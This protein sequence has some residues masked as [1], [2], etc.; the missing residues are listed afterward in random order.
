[1]TI[2][3]T[4]L[5][6]YLVGCLI[7]DGGLHGSLT[8][9]TLDLDIVDRINKC[10]AV[11]GYFL[12]KRSTDIKRSCEYTITP[13]K[14]NN[15]MYEF[16]YKGVVYNGC[17]KLLHVLQ[18]DGYP[19]TSHDSL[20]SIT[21]LSTK[22]KKSTLLS[23]FPELSTMLSGR[24][25]KE[26]QHSTFIQLL[27]RL[28]LRCRFDVKRIPEEYLVDKSF[29]NR[30]LLFQGLMDTDGSISSSNRLE[31]CVSNEQLANDFKKLAESLGF[32]PKIYEKHPKYFNK[33]YNEFR[34]GHI[35]YRVVFHKLENIM[36]FLCLRKQTMYN[37]V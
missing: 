14:N 2:D 34:M 5:D 11:F 22:T 20:L 3:N 25:I 31:F 15:I 37:K 17:S 7:G 30:L 4:K 35:A 21:G 26:N 10:L 36:P 28:N 29:A 23:Y 27:N 12:K 8:F 18:A 16:I 13:I 1:M 19:V 24:K 9:A 6:P 32:K 33:K